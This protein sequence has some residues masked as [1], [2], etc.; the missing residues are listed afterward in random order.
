MMRTWLGST[1]KGSP[2]HSVMIWR[3]SCMSRSLASAYVLT[4][5]VAVIVDTIAAYRS[6]CSSM[7][8]PSSVRLSSPGQRVILLTV[9]RKTRSA[10][11]AEVARALQAQ[12]ICET[13][14]GPAHRAFDREVN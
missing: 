5:C 8:P 1:S 13:E 10:E 12:K 6:A 14:H 2:T 9:F 4:R 11:S 7:C 3:A